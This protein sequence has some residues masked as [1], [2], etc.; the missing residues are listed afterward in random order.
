LSDAYIPP[1]GTINL[2][3]R[4][5]YYFAA[6]R[7]E[8]VRFSDGT[9]WGAETFGVPTLGAYPGDTYYFDQGDGHRR[10]ID[11]DVTG[12]RYGDAADTVRLGVGITSDDISVSRRNG[13]DLVLSL[14][15]TTDE[16]TIQSH[17][18]TV[19]ARERFSFSGAYVNAYQVEQV[20][21]ADGATWN[22]AEL[23]ARVTSIS[24]TD[25]TDAIFANA[26][27]ND[28]DGL[29]GDDVIYGLEGNDTLDGG[30]GNDTLFGSEGSDA[31]RFGRGSGQDTVIDW[32]VTGTDLD[33]ITMA[34]DVL[35]EDV[36]V[37]ADQNGSLVLS[38]NGTA[39]QL[40]LSDF[41]YDPYSQ[42]KQVLFEDGT[43]WDADTLL[44]RAEGP[45]IV[46]TEYS[47]YL[48]GTDL[49]D[50]IIGLEGDDFIDGSGGADVLYGGLDNDE[51]LG[52][53]GNDTL[54]GEA[55]DDTLSGGSGSGG[56]GGAGF[57]A[58]FA[59]GF[60]E[61]DC[62]EGGGGGSHG[63]TGDDILIGGEGHDTYLFNLGDGVDTVRDTALAGDGN[64][65]RFGEGITQ[66]DLFFNHVDDVLTIGV[67]QNGDALRLEGFDPTNANGSLVAETLVFADGTEA[68]LS[69]F[70]RPQPTIVGTAGDDTLIGT[71]DQDIVD[72]SDGNDVVLA[73]DGNDTIDGET[74]NDAL[75]GEAGNDLLTG[76]AGNDNLGGGSGDDTLDGGAGDDVL[77]GEAGADSLLGGEGNDTLY[78]DAG[79]T[80][81][82]VIDGGAGV[83][84]LFIQDT[85][86]VTLDVG[87]ASIE[88]AFGGAGNDTF[89]TNGTGPAVL[90]GEAGNDSLSGGAG[91]DNIEGGMGDDILDGGA[92]DDLLRGDAGVDTLQGGDGN[93]TLYAD[94]DDTVI[95]GGA[96]TD[97]LFVQGATGVTLDVGQASIEVAFGG[98]G[99]DTFT[100]SGPGPAVLR[101][102][103]GNDSL[104]GGAGND[105]I[106]GGLGDDML[107]GGAGDDVLYGG[108]GDDI[109]HFNVGDGQDTIT[110]NV[111][112]SGNMDEVFFGSGIDPLHMILKQQADNLE[113]AF[114][115]TN[116]RLTVRDWFRYPESQ[117]ERL[118]TGDGGRLLNTNVNQLIQAMATYSANSG[119]SWADAIQQRPDEVQAVVA[120]YWEPAPAHP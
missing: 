35:A 97:L 75:R 116:D 89:T 9:T 109:Y 50:T 6:S 26:N 95:D 98:A 92:G 39:D 31:Y 47:D 73:G 107:A 15:G 52:G 23:A 45:T 24:G 30:T 43:V 91:N 42:N 100:T 25:E 110:E 29:A 41:L 80:I 83:D 68:A 67:G 118:T 69:S 2:D 79:D 86:G 33:T 102:E 105:N 12:N 40:T 65:I 88:V 66:A 104:S 63:T 17:F 58:S 81:S 22:A 53:D 4:N 44:S 72:A 111:T 96:G 54:Y 106:E 57:A 74:G 62:G 32:N 59:E 38:V 48:V 77:Y 117:V 5:P 113:L 27:D 82:G 3:N 34:P 21:F 10:I 8:E 114:A 7:V 115:G 56:G 93:D 55:G 37:I 108:E 28:I 84:L 19:F 60:C 119:M 18:S 36:R 70:L 11:F 51:M 1:Q 71:L 120:A 85:R 13:N 14:N 87:Q 61:A 78:T 103:A 99:N 76:G 20:Q 16:L 46:G 49:N 112:A 94:A 101:G 64:R 90:R